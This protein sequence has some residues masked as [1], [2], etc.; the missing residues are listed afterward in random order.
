MS[1]PVFP[2]HAPDISALARSL[3]KQ[4]AEQPQAPSHV[5]MLNMLARALG[6]QN[7]QQFRANAESAPLAPA[8]PLLEPDYAAKRA[9]SAPPS[10]NDIRRLLRHFDAQGRMLRWPGKFSEQLPCIW[11]V[12]ARIPAKREMSERAINEYI[13]LGECFG[14]HVLLRRELVNYQLLA[15]TAD[16]K[17]YRRIE[18]PVPDAILPLLRA[19]LGRA[20]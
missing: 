19:V 20:A 13:K 10:A 2:F 12:W 15:R 5:Q 14:D 4:W 17:V 1:R 6:Q 3:C 11:T 8:L 7:F 16:G 18:Q 9:A